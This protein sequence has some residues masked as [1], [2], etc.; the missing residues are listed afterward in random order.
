MSA[1][2][3][4]SDQPD[5]GSTS[6]TKAAPAITDFASAVAYLYAR[7]N[8]E[9]VS[10]GQTTPDAYKLDR[11][12]ALAAALGNPQETFRTVHI[13]GTKGKGSTCEMIAAMLEACGY[14]VGLYT[15]PHLQDVRERIRLNRQM[16]PQGDFAR[17]AEQVAK[18]A[19]GIE[20]V[21]G[22]ATF[23]EL[24]TMMA[25]LYMAEQAVDV[26]VIEVGLGGKLDCTNII[27]PEVAAVATIGMDHME[28]LGETL[29]KIAVQKAG[30]FKPNVPAI[31]I[32]QDAKVLEAMRGVATQVGAPFEVVGKDCEFSVRF[33]QP[34]NASS[35]QA[36]IQLT[37]QRNDYDFVPVP[38]AGEHQAH[39]CGLALMVVDHLIER[40]LVCPMEQVIQG[41]ATARLPGRFE[42]VN[43]SPRTIFDCAHNP[44]SIRAL[45]K[46]L[47]QYVQYD[48]LTVVF[49]VAMDKDIPP[50]LK[51]LAG[52][53]DKVIFTKA[54]DNKRAADPAWLQKQYKQLDSGV[55]FTT[56]SVPEAMELARKSS[57][58]GDVI[59]V[60]GSFYVVGE[61]RAWLGEKLRAAAQ[62]AQ[63]ARVATR[64]VAPGKPPAARSPQQGKRP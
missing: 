17:L 47:G 19:V 30:I 36:Y 42:V 11:M 31:T 50:M 33:D 59:C 43:G 12:R 57:N 49:G 13:A 51:A 27:T 26:G 28:I 63:A 32:E 48:S 64:P 24:T 58:L 7:P 15:S 56:K 18:A 53:A 38:M 45:T 23:F 40:G 55:S 3:R 20:P 35:P 39:N 54:K 14:T 62:A 8:L 4:T 25:F 60:T 46:T 34:A 21:H 5:S 52:T 2:E 44:E 10:P 6:A 61:G 41:L 29:E 9:R 16:I 1:A 37:T 22:E